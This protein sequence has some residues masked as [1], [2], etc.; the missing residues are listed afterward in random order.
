MLAY[1]FWHEKGEEFEE[2]EYNKALLEF[3]TYY[4]REVRIEG[5]LGS[6][7]VKVYKVPWSNNDAYEDWYF[8]ESSKS[9]DLL[10]DSITSN[11]E[12]KEIH[13]KIAR[14]ARNGKGGLYKLINGDPLS[15]S[16]PHAVWISKPVGVSYDVFYTEIKDI[17]GNLWRKQLAMAPMSEFCIFSKKEI[18]VDE[19]FS[20]IVQKRNLLYISDE[21]K[22]KINT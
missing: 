8:I 5:Y 7:V 17:Q 19:K 16:F 22:K 6:M 12:T 20:P 3:H 1:I 9:L 21:L 11:K 2:D 13:D 4:N 10:N 15:P 18:R 14:M